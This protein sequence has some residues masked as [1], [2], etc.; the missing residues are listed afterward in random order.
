VAQQ[1]NIT[2]DDE[3]AIRK[4]VNTWMAATKTGDIQTVLGL[5]TDDG[6]SHA[7]PTC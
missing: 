5:M 6:G 1:N 3:H 4:L 7:M 2:I